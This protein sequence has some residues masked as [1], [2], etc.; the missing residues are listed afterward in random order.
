MAINK[1]KFKSGIGKL[2]GI[3]LNKQSK[4]RIENICYQK[5]K[6]YNIKKK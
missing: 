3:N 5:M 1:I 2:R 4:N 6:N